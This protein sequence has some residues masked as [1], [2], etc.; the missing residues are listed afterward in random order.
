MPCLASS[1]HAEALSARRQRQRSEV[2]VPW[3]TWHQILRPFPPEE[4]LVSGA[5]TCGLDGLSDRVRG[6]AAGNRP[7]MKAMRAARCPWCSQPLLVLDVWVLQESYSL[8][9]PP[10]HQT[11][12]SWPTWLL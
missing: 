1:L 9:R 5:R 3:A 2:R 7:Q 10:T 6:R 4:M 12:S 8:P 11:F